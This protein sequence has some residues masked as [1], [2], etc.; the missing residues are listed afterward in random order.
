MISLASIRKKRLNIVLASY[1]GIQ[2]KEHLRS[3]SALQ[4][5]LSDIDNFENMTKTGKES[6]CY[7][8][9]HSMMA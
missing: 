5:M 7:W 3:C 4:D 9:A 8:L 6:V 1:I 2:D